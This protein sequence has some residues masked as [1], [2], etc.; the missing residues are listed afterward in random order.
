VLFL[1]EGRIHESGTPDEVLK[2]P[3]EERTR[4]FLARFTE[5]AF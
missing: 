2:H 5:F 1:A 4:S 3:R